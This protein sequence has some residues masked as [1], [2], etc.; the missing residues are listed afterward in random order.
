[1]KKIVTLIILLF[2][3]ITG[4]KAGIGNGTIQ[5]PYKTIE[6]ALSAVKEGDTIRITSGKY[7]P[8]ETSFEIKK[9]VVI[10]GGYDEAFA[11]T[12]PET[13]VLSGDFNGD[14]EYDEDSGILIA[15]YEDNR[16]RVVRVASE[17][18]NVTIENVKIQGGYANANGNDTGG[19]MMIQGNSVTLKN[20][21]F[22]GNYCSAAGGGAIHVR[23]SLNMD[24]CKLI[25]NQGAGDGGA[26]FINGEAVVKVTNTLFQ[27]NTSLAGS[28]VF[29]K[30]AISTY[31][32]ENTF[33]D[34]LSKSYGTFTVY[35]TSLAPERTVTL[36][37]NTF[38]N[39]N[40]EGETEGGANRGGSAIYVRI[41]NDGLV[42]LVNN[43]LIANSCDAQNADGTPASLLGG[44]VFARQGKV[45]MAN[46]VIAGNFSSSGYGD[47]FKTDG[48][49]HSLN[50]NLFGT[51]T[52][53]NI[54]RDN[55]DVL[56]GQDLTSSLY[57]L[58]QTFDVSV[59]G[60]QLNGFAAING[61][62]TPTIKILD[63]NTDRIVIN[64]IPVENLQGTTLG[65]DLNND[66]TLSGQLQ[67]D[68][69]GVNRNSE[70]NACIG[71]YEIG[72]ATGRT[73]IAEH[74]KLISISGNQFKV[75]SAYPF[76]Y[77][78]YD[79]LG[80]PVQSARNQAPETEVDLRNLCRGGIYLIKVV[81][82]NKKQI[83]KLFYK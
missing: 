61:G 63:E 1:M 2:M 8:S 59:S 62:K 60:N 18:T 72:T 35:N 10:I 46:N 43:T 15:G 26:M 82:G 27:Y 11:N 3:G 74:P 69:R 42:N 64:T 44:A 17:A 22:M 41:H 49:V 66:G 21:V 81:S 33:L 30:N 31:F 67:K 25:G 78:V 12:T 4:V 39:N 73:L 83:N 58:A 52:S 38:A 50:Y 24:N 19:G 29:L 20:V 55:D 80:K 36:V 51:N 9:G 77:V 56:A 23:T 34:N 76:D 70:G 53:I 28:A 54:N 65:I 71:A 7:I 79:I 75:H 48:V 16:Y 37:N 57:A 68:Q 6:Q 47:V 45:K 32:A 13:T 40:V 14:D 5:S